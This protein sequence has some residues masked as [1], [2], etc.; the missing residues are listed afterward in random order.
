[1]NNLEVINLSNDI[2]NNYKRDVFE[3]VKKENPDSI[4]AN[5]S[6]IIV[7]KY[8]DI[9]IKSKKIYFFILSFNN[10]LLGYAILANKPKYLI[11]K[12]LS[13]PF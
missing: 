7:Y 4:L 2:N 8:F 3:I 1:M 5:L 10:S 13:I 12:N 9:A 6:E 11:N